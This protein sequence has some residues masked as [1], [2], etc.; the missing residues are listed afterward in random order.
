[1][2]CQKS[3]LCEQRHELEIDLQ[4]D[5][6]VMTEPLTT[7]RIPHLL[8]ESIEFEISPKKVQS[9]SKILSLEHDSTK[10][11]KWEVTAVNLSLSPLITYNI[12]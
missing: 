1:M 11:T 9:Q 3:K 12:S 10:N 7:R 8:L 4:P 2:G 5:D 6:S